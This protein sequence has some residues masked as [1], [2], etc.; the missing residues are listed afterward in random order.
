MIFSHL[1]LIQLQLHAAYNFASCCV[2]QPNTLFWW[3]SPL[4][5]TDL[6]EILISL[7]L[8]LINLSLHPVYL[9]TYYFVCLWTIIMATH[10]YCN[11][12]IQPVELLMLFLIFLFRWNNSSSS[13]K[14]LNCFSKVGVYN[15]PMKASE[16]QK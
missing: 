1:Y 11:M 5:H 7:F 14:I 3:V 13:S 8:L 15:S 12:L 10:S 2:I 4:S 9:A 16:Q 6:F